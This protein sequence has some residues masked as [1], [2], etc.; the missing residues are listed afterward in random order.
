MCKERIRR[1]IWRLKN[2][3]KKGQN[4]FP[5]VLYFIVIAE[6]GLLNKPKG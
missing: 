6:E 1:R 2:I 4:Q 3:L 5:A